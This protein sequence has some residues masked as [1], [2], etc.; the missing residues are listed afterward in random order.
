MPP[1]PANQ[2]LNQHLD[3][4]AIA[5]RNKKPFTPNEL[6]AVRRYEQVIKDLPVEHGYV[7]DSTGMP[8]HHSV[9]TKTGV[10]IVP[11]RTEGFDAPAAVVTH[12]HPG[13]YP[14]LSGGDLDVAARHGLPIRATLSQVNAVH[15]WTPNNT[16]AEYLWGKGDEM[17]DKILS[18]TP[19]QAVNFRLKEDYPAWRANEV[20]P[21]V[22]S[23][24]PN[25]Y[26][27]LAQGDATRAAQIA[28][29]SARENNWRQERAVEMEAELPRS[30]NPIYQR[31]DL[32]T[33]PYNDTMATDSFAIKRKP[34]IAL[35]PGRSSAGSYDFDAE[36][37]AMMND[38]L[39]RYGY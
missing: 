1:I 39:A 35:E 18:G 37:G 7:F 33:T 14:S 28:Q 19:P 22:D 27:D 5:L 29:E 11:P 16:P 17:T 30:I 9:G 12:N 4:V 25:D 8:I 15:E 10:V 32:Y 21:R 13:G 34:M 23:T 3:N 20:I 38:R 6:P 2:L 31:H 36:F 26:M 24:N